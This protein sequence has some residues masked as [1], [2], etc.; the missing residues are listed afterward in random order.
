MVCYQ[1]KIR[2]AE[3]AQPGTARDWKSRG[4]SF[5]QEF[6]SPPR[7]NYYNICFNNIKYYFNI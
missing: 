1:I 3:V 5:P 6:K 2:F 4:N 7:R